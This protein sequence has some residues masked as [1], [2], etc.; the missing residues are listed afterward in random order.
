MTIWADIHTHTTASDGSFTPTALV[1]H[2]KTCG[3]Q[4]L[5]ITDHDTVAAYEEA[6]PIAKELGIVL[7]TGIEFSTVFEGHDVHILGYDI[8]LSSP[9]LLELCHRHKN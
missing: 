4:G 2:A 9:E 1:R 3:L 5:S 7:G 6:I 8:T